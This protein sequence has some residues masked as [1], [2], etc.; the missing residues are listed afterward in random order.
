MGSDDDEPGDAST[1]L[2]PRDEAPADDQLIEAIESEAQQRLWLRAILPI[3]AARSRDSDPSA[4]VQLA[5]DLM[6][7]AACERVCRIMRS[8]LPLSPD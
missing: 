3:L 8:D 7:I 4:H 2:R 1:E 6:H 5:L